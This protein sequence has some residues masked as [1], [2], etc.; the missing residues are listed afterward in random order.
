MTEKEFSDRAKTG[1][2]LLF[3]G[4]EFPGKFQ[5]FFTQAEYGIYLYFNVYRPFSIVI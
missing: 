5:R 1:D 4:F 3:R 2:I